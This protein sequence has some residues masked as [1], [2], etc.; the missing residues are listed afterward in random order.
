MKVLEQTPSCLKIQVTGTGWAVVVLALGLLLI[1]VGVSQADPDILRRVTA[2]P[3]VGDRLPQL[4]Y[5]LFFGMMGIVT[6]W[7][8]VWF[9]DCTKTY[10]FDRAANRLSIHTRFLLRTTEVCYSFQTVHAV[11]VDW[12]EDSDGDR[13]LTIILVKKVGQPIYVSDIVQNQDEAEYQQIAETIRVFLF[14]K[15]N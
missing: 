2:E 15:A 4:V 8:S 1:A 9:M 11:R 6:A 10:T 3:T 5:A 7:M 12:L 14:G 13:Y